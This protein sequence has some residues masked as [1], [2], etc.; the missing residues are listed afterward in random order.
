MR[1][2]TVLLC[3]LNKVSTTVSFTCSIRQVFVYFL[4]LSLFIGPK[5]VLHKLGLFD[6]LMSMAQV[7]VC[8]FNP[9]FL[10][11][12]QYSQLGQLSV[13]PIT[14]AEDED[15]KLLPVSICKESYKRGSIN[16]SEEGFDIDAQL[17]EG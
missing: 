2:T 12:I 17:E 14:Y 7:N 9:R 1:M 6:L 15:G 3:T 11:L 5:E 10:V 13:G 4:F 8:V 16:S